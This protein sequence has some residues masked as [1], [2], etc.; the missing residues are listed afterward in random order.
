MIEELKRE[1][2]QTLGRK[3]LKRGD[4]ELLAD[5]LY[6]K[7]GT[8]VSYNTF[9][10]L[11]GI[12]EYRK[13]R[14]ST[15]DALSVYIGFESFQDFTKRFS[16]VDTW[17]VWEHLYVMLSE[18]NSNEILRYLYYRKRQQD[19][20]TIA[21]TIV[22]RELLNRKDLSTLLLIFRD[23]LFQFKALP[24]D[25]VAQIGVLIGLHFRTFQDKEAEEILLL[26]PNFRD[27][28]FKIFV[29]YGRLNGK[30][31]QW[32]D[33]LSEIKDLDAETKMF[34][35]CLQ[36]WRA[37]LN[38][39]TQDSRQLQ[40]LPQLDA[41]QHPILFGR[42]FGLHTLTT[43]SKKKLE[44]LRGQME[45]RIS[46][47]PHF[48]TELLYE[49]AVQALVLNSQLHEQILKAHQHQINRINFWYHV[50]QVAIHRVLQVKMLLGERQYLVAKS[51][52]EHIPYG[53]IRHGY[54]EFIELYVA[55][56]RWHIAKSLNEPSRELEI[57]FSMRKTKL[58]YPIF[59]DAYF[60]S[61][62]QTY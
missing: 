28:V 3:V 2:E 37:L 1:V 19:Q 8:V 16:E 42:L 11:F 51:M 35:S 57:E 27:L 9:R 14:E 20:F 54:R 50:S 46:Q 4:C 44:K 24:Y 59:T 40:L 43:T 5:D 47:E 58:H 7:T 15:L 45:Q 48:V 55:F 30:Y 41:A 25:Q 52:L 13:P 31:G 21:F 49:P 17:P 38:L 61:Y 32:I 53:H 18:G 12:I 62:F 22:V 39:K 56:F 10:R 6:Q 34:L 26:E 60:E 29:D 23:P 33:Y 36:I